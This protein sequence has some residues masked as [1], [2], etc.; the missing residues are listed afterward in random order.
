MEL[1]RVVVTGLGLVTPI[2]T[3]VEL[4]WKRLLEGR[5]GISRSKNST[6]QTFLPRSPPKSFAVTGKANSILTIGSRRKTRRKMADFIIFGLAA[7]QQAIE[8]A[9]WKP[10]TEEQRYRTGV[11]IGSGIGGLNE[12]VEGAETLR[13]RGPRRLSPFFIPMALINL[14]SGPHLHS[15]WVQ[16][17]QPRRGHSAVLLVHMPSA[18][19]RGSSAWT[20]RM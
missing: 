19:P 13:E 3:G 10:E 7:A 15:L 16:G 6:S 2:G 5:S 8:D 4:T 20:M 18:M 1:R 12:I 14:V 11:L 9:N 17:A